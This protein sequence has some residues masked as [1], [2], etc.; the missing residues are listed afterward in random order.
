MLETAT[1]SI[2][3]RAT[4]DINNRQFF[5]LRLIATLRLPSFRQWHNI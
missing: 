3:R 1:A 2:H 4:V 5:W